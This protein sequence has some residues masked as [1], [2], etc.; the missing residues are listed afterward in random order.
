MN[1]IDSEIKWKVF[2]THIERSMEN[3][4]VVVVS[5]S[6]TFSIRMEI[7]VQMSWCLL[8]LILSLFITVVKPFLVLQTKDS[9]IFDL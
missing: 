9:R 8:T 2:P 3:Y 4:C 5:F 1:G 7:S 6:H